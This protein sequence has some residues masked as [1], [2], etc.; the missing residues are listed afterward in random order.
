[1]IRAVEHV[2]KKAEDVGKITDMRVL[3]NLPL[4]DTLFVNG[5]NVEWSRVADFAQLR[6]LHVWNCDQQLDSLFEHALFLPLKDLEIRKCLQVACLKPIQKFECLERL[7]LQGLGGLGFGHSL[8]HSAHVI[9]TF[10]NL[11][12]LQLI[13]CLWLRDLDWI[14]D[15]VKLSSLSL[16]GCTHVRSLKPLRGLTQLMTLDLNNCARLAHAP[17]AV[18]SL[19]SLWQLRNFSAC[20]WFPTEGLIVLMTLTHLR[21]VDVQECDFERET[22]KQFTAWCR[23]KKVRCELHVENPEKKTKCRSNFPRHFPRV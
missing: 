12:H 23:R 1:M 17:D 5:R 16:S 19:R 11:K 7:S 22:R 4:L 10:F 3:A 14:E 9:G 2:L 15:L 18:K 8:H 20:G 13:D 6:T 21:Q